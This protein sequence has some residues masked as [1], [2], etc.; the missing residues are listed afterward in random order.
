MALLPPK[1]FWR[2]RIGLSRFRQFEA[3]RSSSFER[4]TSPRLFR[5]RA[6]RS[7]SRC[8][9]GLFGHSQTSI[10]RA[11]FTRIVPGAYAEHFRHFFRLSIRPSIIRS[12]ASKERSPTLRTNRTQTRSRRNAPTRDGTRCISTGAYLFS[13]LR[14]PYFMRVKI[15]FRRRPLTASTPGSISGFSAPFFR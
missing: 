12:S 6:R 7:H 8:V 3:T 14:N 1:R 11:L 13:Y 9:G 5:R 15:A 4:S 10:K 2:I